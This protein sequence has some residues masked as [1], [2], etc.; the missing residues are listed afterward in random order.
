M[1]QGSSE[2]TGKSKSSR[3]IREFEINATPWALILPAEVKAEVLENGAY[4]SLRTGLEFR[5]EESSYQKVLCLLFPALI[6]L[7]GVYSEIKLAVF[8]PPTVLPAAVGT[9]ISLFRRK[10]RE[11]LGNYY[12]LAAFV[13]G[14]FLFFVNREHFVS[15]VLGNVTGYFVRILYDYRKKRFYRIIPSDKSRKTAAYCLIEKD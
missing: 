8:S 5:I 15:Y 9:G 3:K 2:H 13:F 14:I 11:L 4:R 6:V 7:I 1:Q 10:G 12:Y